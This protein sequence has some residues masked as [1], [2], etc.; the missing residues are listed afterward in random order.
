[1]PAVNCLTLNYAYPRVSYQ[2]LENISLEQVRNLCLRQYGNCE[3]I[4]PFNWSQLFPCVER[5]HI[6]INSKS[7]IQC[8]LNQF[9]NLISGYFYRS[10]TDRNRNKSIEITYSW[11]EKRISSRKGKTISNF[12]Y[13]IDSQFSFSL[14]LWIN[15]VSEKSYSNHLHQ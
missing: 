15:R 4:K 1:M 9:N 12:N 14:C 13:Q 11:L 7:H 2:C 8:L 3:G 5:L 10:L 6:S